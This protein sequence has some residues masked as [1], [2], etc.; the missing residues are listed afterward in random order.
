[1][2][3]VKDMELDLDKS[4]DIDQHFMMPLKEVLLGLTLVTKVKDRKVSVPYV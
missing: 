2:G 1:M 4:K 3:S